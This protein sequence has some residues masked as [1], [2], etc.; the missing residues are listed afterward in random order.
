MSATDELPRPG[1]LALGGAAIQI[2][3]GYEHTCA[4]LDRRVRCWGLDLG[5]SR[6]HRTSAT[7]AA[8]RRPQVDL[9]SG[10]PVR[11]ARYDLQ[12]PRSDEQATRRCLGLVFPRTG[13]QCRRDEIGRVRWGG[14][15][16]GRREAR[17][18]EP[19]ARSD[20]S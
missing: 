11:W 2:D 9:R 17:L 5:R 20:I 8:E 6:T 12:R 15:R 19:E 14:R 4:L 18:L 10:G 1:P 16:S 13:A 7:T 3:A